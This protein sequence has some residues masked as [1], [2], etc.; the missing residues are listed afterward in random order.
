MASVAHTNQAPTRA[1]AADLGS[2]LLRSKGPEKLAQRVEKPVYYAL[3]QRNDGI[4]GNGDVLRANL[5]AALGD[6]A[7]PDPVLLPQIRHAILGINRIHLQL[8]SV[9]QE[10]RPDKFVEQLMIP[11]DVANVLAEKAL[12]ALAKFLR[13]VDIGLIHAPRPIRRVRLARF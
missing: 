8:R 12:D 13:A 1:S 7:I 3:L 9:N 6:V 5:G 2:A 10:S 4:V 11:Q